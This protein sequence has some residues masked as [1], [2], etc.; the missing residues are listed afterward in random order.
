MF[1]KGR[2]AQLTLKGDLFGGVTTAIISLPLALAFGVAS[3]A[4]AEAGLWG[5]I[6]VGLFASLF[7]GS[8][9]LISEPTGP[10]TVIMT[11]V[12]TAMMSRYPEGGV[13]MAFTVVM[14]AGAFQILIGSLRL[15]KYVTLMPYSVVSGFMSGIGVILILLQLAPLLGQAAPT[16]GALGTLK[17]LPDL[18]SQAD[19][20]EVF[21]G[22]LT[23]GILFYF[24]AKY[25]RFIPAQLVALVSI[26]LVSIL[27]FD[28]DSIRRIGEIPTGLPS[29]VLP[30]ITAEHFTAMVIDALVLGTLGCIDTLLTAVIADSLTRQEHNSDREL[31]GQGVANMIAGLFGALPGAG[32]TMGTVVNVQVGARS[33]LSGILRAAMLAAVVLVAGAL[34]AP[35]PM[36]VL[37]G[38][39]LYVGFNILDWSFLHRAH[40]ISLQQTGIMYGVMALT[41]FVDLIVAVGLGVFIANLLVIERLSREQAKQVRAIS[42]A[43]DD[44]VPLDD[45]ERAL[46]D[47]SNGQVLFF[48]LSGPMI[49]SVSKAIARQHAHI[50]EFRVMILD[51]SDVPMLDMTVG[52]ALEN[53]IKDAREA[54]CT[55]FLLCPHD[56]TREQL[57]RLHIGDWVRDAHIFTTRKPALEA[58]N[59]LVE[60]MP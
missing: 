2:F 7:G 48:Y 1:D 31:R 51:L 27:L 21:L 6:L 24:P 5:A 16:G 45:E 26:T 53:A 41:V 52:L 11:T 39:A 56:E 38:I 34:T 50:N 17:A 42:D 37:A 58:A 23:L 59:R 57:Q 46:L 8:S 32:A 13:A 55:V 25:R 12:L 20:K 10:M 47:A 9:T 36:A 40:K 30:H 18:L 44:E 22:V 29:L 4:G 28:T 33:P 49:F 43:E 35:I 15:G 19:I 60:V 54:E 3:G 14:M